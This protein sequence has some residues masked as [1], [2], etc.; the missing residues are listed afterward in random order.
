MRNNKAFTLVELLAVIALLGIIGLIVSFSINNILDS[1]RN[2]LYAE[3][4]NEII[5]TTKKYA[6]EHPNILPTNDGFSNID[7]DT[8]IR[9]GYLK[10]EVTN[11]Q[12]KYI[13]IDPKNNEEL[14]GLVTVI[15][16]SDY[17]Q[18]DYS[19]STSTNIKLKLQ[20]N[21]G[22][23]CSD[24]VELSIYGFYDISFY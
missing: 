11:D 16:N 18:Y 8:L 9:S 19:F 12:G 1:N 17:N 3:Q 7:I 23:G 15:Y 22:T 14:K 6:V 20:S 2:N 4:V 24:E 13:I 5:N 21:G 10:A